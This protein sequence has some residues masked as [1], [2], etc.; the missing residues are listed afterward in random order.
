MPVAR[1]GVLQ[2]GAGILKSHENQFSALA[3]AITHGVDASLIQ[4]PEVRE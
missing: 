2:Q 3:T 4:V 1:I